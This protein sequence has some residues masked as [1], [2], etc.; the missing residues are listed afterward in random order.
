MNRDNHYEA[1]FEAFL[2]TLGVAVVAVD[3]ARRSYLDEESI[4]SPDFL[5][6]GPHDARLV[7]DVKGR[8][9]PGG[10]AEHPRMVWQNW[11]TR[12]DITGLERWASRFGPGFRGVLAF[13]YHILPCVELPEATPDLFAFRER[14]YLMRGVSV[15]EYRSAMRQRSP[16]W[17]TVHLATA[18]F[19]SVV[20]PFSYFL[21]P[22]RVESEVI[23]H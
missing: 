3:E 19:R 22:A 21:A 11:S 14:V 9:F 7:V 6:V 20:K 23:E 15:A 2:R 12:E 1:A 10:T 4:K 18:A 13:V 17:G 5:V 8:K 16:R